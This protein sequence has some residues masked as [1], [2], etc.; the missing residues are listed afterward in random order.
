MDRF[1]SFSVVVKLLEFSLIACLIFVES[2]CGGGELN[3]GSCRLSKEV[4]GYG[5]KF[6]HSGGLSRFHI[7]ALVRRIRTRGQVTDRKCALV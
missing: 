5:E 2:H 3:L 1:L 6:S 4:A 7:V